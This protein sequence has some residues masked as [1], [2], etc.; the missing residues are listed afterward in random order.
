MSLVVP[1]LLLILGLLLVAAEVFFPS[2]GILALLASASVGS[3]VVLAFLHIGVNA[4][5]VFLLAI[6]ILVPLT[7][8]L[9]FKILPSTPFGKRLILA[10]PTFDETT[11]TAVTKGL[12]SLVGKKGTALS[13]LRPAGV[14]SIDGKRVDVVTRGVMI[15]KGT[16][17]QVTR[18]EGNRVVVDPLPPER[19]GDSPGGG[20]LMGEKG[21][22]EPE[23]G[24]T[25]RGGSR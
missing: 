21:E 1:I 12:E 4:G 14:A 10:G 22:Q 25:D 6:L 5:I 16:P 15:E 17:I 19:K 8:L 24:G 18:I 11:G 3:A 9:A 23:A 2:M 20:S 13:P 7:L